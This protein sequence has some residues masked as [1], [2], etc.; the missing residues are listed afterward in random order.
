MPEVAGQRHPGDVAERA[1]Q[2]DARRP[3][4]DDRERQPFPAPRSS[5]SRSA[6]SKARRTLR[7]IV[8]RVL[9]R[10][11]PRR[12]LL[13]FRMAEIRVRRPGRDDQAVV[14]QFAVGQDHGFPIQVD[15]DDVGEQDVGVPLTSKNPADRPRD[16]ARVR[17][18][19]SP[20][21][22]TAAG[23]DDGSG[24]RPPTAAPARRRNSWIA[25]KPP[26]PAP[27]TTT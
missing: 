7:R 14:S 26:K 4:A 25:A 19:R 6:I 15:I 24:G 20:P 1:R 13:P 22:T 18:R 23:R 3:A 16:V 21:G 8:R 11:Q 17:A 27:I 12:E 9:D 5:V 10:L 2:L